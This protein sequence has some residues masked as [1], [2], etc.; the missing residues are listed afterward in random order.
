MKI[1]Q[2]YTDA[3]AGK[4]PSVSFVDPN[5]DTQ[6]EENRRHPRRREFAAKVIN[7]VMQ[8]PTWPKTVLI[9]TYDE[10]GGYYDHVAPPPAIKP[11]NIRPAPT[12]PRPA[13]GYDRYGFRVPDGRR[14]AVRQDATTCRTSCTTT[15]RS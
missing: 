13:G 1:D 9:Y 15:R 8:V 12:R 11:D 2:F 7:A 5:F 3:A 14:V 6:S 10:H 4:L